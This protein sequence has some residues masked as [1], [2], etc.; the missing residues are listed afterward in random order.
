MSGL[1]S[2]R[3]ALQPTEN[4]R[5]KLKNYFFFQFSKTTGQSIARATFF[6]KT[7]FSNSSS[8]R[9]KNGLRDFDQNFA[10]QEGTSD[11]VLNF[12]YDLRA[13]FSI[14]FKS[15]LSR[16]SQIENI[17]SKTT[18]SPQKNVHFLGFYSLDVNCLELAR[19]FEDTNE[20]PP[21]GL[22]PIFFHFWYPLGILKNVI[23]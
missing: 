18:T 7:T 13:P 12:E 22:G 3:S 17:Q 11:L 23:K 21:G 10:D 16:A 4:C 6:V 19:F 5:R 15:N 2:N 1:Q 9:S 8:K 14:F 20:D